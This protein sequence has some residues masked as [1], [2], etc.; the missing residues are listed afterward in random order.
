MLGHPCKKEGAFMQMGKKAV[1]AAA[2]LLAMSSG[3]AGF[4]SAQAKPE[5]GMPKV[6]D[7][8]PDF[9]LHYFN[10]TDSKEVNLSDY[11]GKKNVILAFY[12]FAFT[13]G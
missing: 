12:I 1:Q 3:L 7:K 5:S 10:G 11:L 8:A 4:A 9:T 13:G 2:L 6:G